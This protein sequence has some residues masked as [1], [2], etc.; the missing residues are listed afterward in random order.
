MVLLVI[1]WTVAVLFFLKIIIN[2]LDAYFQVHKFWKSGSENSSF[3][4]LPPVEIVL[5]LVLIILSIFVK[6]DTI[7]YNV[8]FVMGGGVLIIIFSYI[9]L[10]F[11]L[12]MFGWIHSMLTHKR[13]EKERKR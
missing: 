7:Y 3:S 11:M 4:L 1:Y 9:H 13:E 10:F 6:D 12:F 2:L 8:W 5:W